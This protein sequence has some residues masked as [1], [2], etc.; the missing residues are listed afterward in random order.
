[1]EVQRHALRVIERLGIL[2]LGMLLVANL[3]GIFIFGQDHP[4]LMLDFLAG[5]VLAMAATLLVYAVAQ[6]VFAEGGQAVKG[7]LFWLGCVAGAASA[8]IFIISIHALTQAA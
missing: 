6:M 7:L 1:M 4:A 5:W 3:G 2:M 8:L